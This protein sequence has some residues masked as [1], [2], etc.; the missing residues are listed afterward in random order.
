M[1]D[2]T[3]TTAALL[4]LVCASAA[5]GAQ[6]WR[7][8][9]LSFIAG[10][11]PADPLALDLWVTF[12]GPDQRT[13]TVP[14]FWD[15]GDTWRVRFTPTLA[16]VW[17]YSTSAAEY[18]EVLLH[19]GGTLTGLDPAHFIDLDITGAT[20]LRLIVTDGGDDISWDHADW[21]I[22]T[23]TGP[24]GV[25]YL[26]DLEPISVEQGHG[27]LHLGSNLLGDP[28]RIGGVE[29]AR[30]LGTHSYGEIAYALDGAAEGFSAWVGLDDVVADNGSV[31][32]RVIAHYPVGPV[33]GLDGQSGSFTA[34]PASGDNPLYLHGG[35]LQVSNNRRYL[36]Y[37]DGTPFFWLG[38]TWWFCPG[39]LMPFDSSS[40]PEI[41]SCLRHVVDR[42]AAQGYTIAHMG[43]LSS[44]SAGVNHFSDFHTTHAVDPPYW[45]EVDNSIDYA[46]EAGIIP[47]LG[48][49]FHQGL[50]HL[51]LWEWRTLWRYTIARYGAHA[52][53]WLVCGEY[54]QSNVE[55]RVNVALSLGRFIK[56]TDP[57]GRAMTIHPWWYA[58]EGRQAWGEDWYDFTM[59]QGAH[60]VGLAPTIDFYLSVYD[61]SPTRPMLEG[62][63]RYEG[64]HDFTDVDVRRAAYRA[65]QCGSFGYTYGAHGLWYPNQDWDDLT[66]SEWGTPVPWWV[67]LER[68]G[69]EQ[70][71]HLRA[72]YEMVEW[73]ELIPLPGCIAT[74]DDPLGEGERIIA[75]GEADSTFVVYF[76]Q[77]AGPPSGVRLTGPAPGTRYDAVWFDPRD[78]SSTH[79]P[80]LL[81]TAGG[82]L[83]LPERPDTQD[84]LL[85]LRLAGPLEASADL[86]SGWN[87][88]SLPLWPADTDPEA[89]F[90]DLTPPN[91]L[92]NAIFRYSGAYEI[93]P[94]DFTAM[95]RGAGY[96]L[97]LDTGGPCAME[98]TR[99]WVAQSIPLQTGWNLVGHP[100]PDAVRWADCRISD[101]V[102]SL[103]L[104]DAAAAGWVDPTA[105]YYSG[106]S[107]GAVR[108]GGTGDD[109]S[110]RPWRGYW[111]LAN[112]S[113]LELVVP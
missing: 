81:D 26:D 8:A 59:L 7:V 74:D 99:A 62:E 46:N 45:Q 68:P 53:G 89:V 3:G 100:S 78:G 94:V 16:G 39:D 82:E 67:A 32:F 4:L 9:E 84:W 21:G 38:D 105:Y 2:F 76:P 109:D 33:A 25:T 111:V 20:T 73:W 23:I 5:A 97:Y 36:T 69:G 75:K 48:L 43:F 10:Q 90:D 19:D 11:P 13:Y 101:G 57:Y 102:S 66:F 60:E 30:G 49:A 28:L 106:A 65:L 1:R 72:L 31:A 71:T 83:P 70:M 95:E 24:G 27:V 80:E 86:T 22:A 42:R 107:Y 6:Q 29:F 108:A 34:E 63:C 103:P 61:G 52:V 92:P 85:L 77:D 112:Q 96:W 91:S 55:P 54:N 41:E 14:G 98:G 58:G 56:E 18:S 35:T 40:N 51:T 113:G 17:S 44:T 104:P 88:L 64:I 37:A 12:T 47:V 79:L 50:D 87:L 15:G 110:L 93:Y